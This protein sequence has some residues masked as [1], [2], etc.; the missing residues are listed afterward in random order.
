MHDINR[1]S[2]NLRGSS[3]PFQELESW[4]EDGADGSHWVKK[5]PDELRKTQDLVE[6]SSDPETAVL[7]EAE[8]ICS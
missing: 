8:R 5:D 7:S 2:K 1:R 3:P 4:I 6:K